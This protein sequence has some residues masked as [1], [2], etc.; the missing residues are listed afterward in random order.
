M[1]FVDYI[2]SG[3]QT[4]DCYIFYFEYFYFQFNL[5]KFDLI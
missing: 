2:K 1:L 4:F 5:L 3:P